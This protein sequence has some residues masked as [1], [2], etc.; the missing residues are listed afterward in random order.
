[1]LQEVLTK[2]GI[3]GALKRAICWGSPEQQSKL[4][5]PERLRV[6]GI[7][8]VLRFELARNSRT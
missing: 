7:F 2:K 4:Q 5:I 6:L 1:M 3:V 8:C